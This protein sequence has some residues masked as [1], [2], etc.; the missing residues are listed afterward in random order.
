MV[1]GEYPF[2]GWF[3]LVPPRSSKGAHADDTRGESR[4]GYYGMECLVGLRVSSMKHG[5]VH[6]PIIGL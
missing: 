4:E 3:G 2:F 1:Q 6:G 5:V